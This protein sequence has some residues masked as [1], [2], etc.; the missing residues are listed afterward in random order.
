MKRKYEKEEKEISSAKFLLKLLRIS[1]FLP[2]AP[3]PFTN[4]KYHHKT[5]HYPVIF[6][7][8]RLN[9]FSEF[10][11]LFLEVCISFLILHL[12]SYFPYRIKRKKRKG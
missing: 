5:Q 1:I 6:Y 7:H 11:R 3:Y 9:I 12:T 2:P 10:K 4:I 8:N